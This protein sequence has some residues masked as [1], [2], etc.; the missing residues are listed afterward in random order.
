[1]LCS[2]WN[3]ITSMRPR[4]APYSFR[5]PTTAPVY[6]SRKR[7]SKSS[8]YGLP[9]AGFARGTILIETNPGTS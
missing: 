5:R 7:W 2:R 6:G 8:S 1:M 3:G 4:S 9:V